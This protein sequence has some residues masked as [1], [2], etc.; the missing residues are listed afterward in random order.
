M[1][2]ES[3]SS[4][5]FSSPD[6]PSLSITCRKLT[7]PLRISSSP[8]GL[9]QFVGGLMSFVAAIALCSSSAI[10]RFSPSTRGLTGFLPQDTLAR[11]SRRGRGRDAAER[12]LQEAAHVAALR[13]ARQQHQRAELDAVRVRLDLDR[14]L[15][16]LARR[17]REGQRLV[18]RPVGV[19]A[20]LGRGHGPR[21]VD[22]GVRVRERRVLDVAVDEALAL[23]A[24]WRR[25]RARPGCRAPGASRP[26]SRRGS[27]PAR[28]CGCR[29]GCRRRGPP[30]ACPR[31]S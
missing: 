8:I 25:S 16:Q 17:A 4:W 27:R 13:L 12:R 21:V 29:A 19:V 1:P 10:A 23:S 3:R 5:V 15:G 22:R 31:G 9:R 24:S 2:A 14:L 30:C 7:S 11:M 20:A 6:S 18:A 28:S 26:A